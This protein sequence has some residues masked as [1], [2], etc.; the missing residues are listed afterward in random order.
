MT[1]HSIYTLTQ[2]RSINFSGFEYTI[3]EETTN[4]LNYLISQLSNASHTAYVPNKS[5]VSSS[6]QVYKSST[7]SQQLAAKKRKGNKNMEVTS[8][9]WESI[10]TF[11]PTKMAVKSG[12]D[13]TLDKIRLHLNKITDKTFIDIREKIIDLIRTI[14]EEY[15]TDENIAKL[16]QSVYDISSTNKFYSKLFADLYAE[17]LTEFPF[18]KS[19]FDKA[20]SLYEEQFN[21]IEYVDADTNYDQFCEMNKLNE[22][23]RANTQFYVNLGLNGFISPLSI[24]RILK[25]LV[26]LIL[27]MVKLPNKKNEVDEIT[28]NIALLYNTDLLDVAEDDSQYSDDELYINEMEIP[29][30]LTMFTNTKF[31]SLSNKSTFKYMDILKM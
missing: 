19:V 24:A 18:L 27:D 17:L 13:E 29:E 10:R 30:V 16:S 26:Q 6:Q 11:Q 31:P 1:Q 20:F 7:S 28:E 23:R 15:K 14:P 3:P 5:S 8:D 25:H 2:I 22:R 9:D 4:K 12:F 21:H